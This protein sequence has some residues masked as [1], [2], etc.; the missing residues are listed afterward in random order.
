MPLVSS[1]SGYAA[2]ERRYTTYVETARRVFD[3]RPGHK[4]GKAVSVTQQ[5]L[6]LQLGERD[7][8][9]AMPDSTPIQVGNLSSRREFPCDNTIYSGNIIAIWV[10][11]HG[12][13]QGRLQFT[14]HCS[15]EPRSIW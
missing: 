14:T 12:E 15:G 1:V 3:T 5:S 6:E 7:A 10:R 9:H 13:A 4:M 2:C 11:E 8:S